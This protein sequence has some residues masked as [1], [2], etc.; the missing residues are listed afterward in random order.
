MP[1][2]G[3][4]STGSP[5]LS[6]DSENAAIARLHR[7]GGEQFVEELAVLFLQDMPARLVTMHD[8]LTTRDAVAMSRAAH[9]MKSSSAQLGA[10][11]LAGACG[12]L[13]DAADRDD[14][15]AAERCLHSV[16]TEYATFSA[17]L[18]ARVHAADHWREDVGPNEG[19]AAPT[20]QATIAVVEDNADNR[21]LVDAILGDRFE[22]HA[23]ASGA[24]ALTGMAQ[25]IPDLVLLDVSLP[26]MDGV[27]VMTRIRRDA[28]WAA[29]P[30]VALT[31][32]AMAGDRDRYL[33]AG[34]DAYVA[35]PIVDERDL[36]DTIERLLARRWRGDPAAD[37]STQDQP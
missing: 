32:H 13:E 31:A 26:G 15:P 28:R 34:F 25:R 29:I 8:A 37:A 33:A 21:L 20:M 11:R 6:R 18:A 36:I 1:S 16:D 30:V 19:R 4:D 23:Y 9:A 17:W 3:H 5:H 27:D 2:H 12:E 7:I 35:K 24:E 14:L 10:E 22:L